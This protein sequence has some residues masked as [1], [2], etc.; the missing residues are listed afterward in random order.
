MGSNKTLLVNGE[1]HLMLSSV[2]LSELPHI[3]M[4]SLGAILLLKKVAEMEKYHALRVGVL[5]VILCLVIFG[6]VGNGLSVSNSDP[7][8]CP[9]N[10]YCQTEM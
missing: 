3:V 4:L 8:D 9:D 7:V 10:H 5:T 6:L 2:N 1:T